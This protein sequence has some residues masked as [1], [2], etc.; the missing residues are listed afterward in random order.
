MKG[1]Y[2]IKKCR[3][4]NNSLMKVLNIQDESTKYGNKWV[5]IDGIKFQSKKEGGYYQFLKAEKLAGRIIDF[6][7]Q[8]PFPIH[9]NNVLICKYYAD[10]VVYYPNGKVNVIDVKG[11]KTDIYKLKRKMIS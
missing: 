1:N 4:Q 5:E 8:V 3:G 10:F 6:K 2:K 7:M 9:I 11:F